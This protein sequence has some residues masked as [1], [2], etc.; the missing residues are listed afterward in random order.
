MADTKVKVP[1]VCGGGCQATVN[2]TLTKRGEPRLPR[3]RNGQW[4]RRED[5]VYCPVC[6]KKLFVL[7]AVTFPVAECLDGEWKDFGAAVRSMCCE[8]ARLANWATAELAKVEPVPTKGKMPDAPPIY[9]YGLLSRFAR[10]GAWAGAMSSAQSILQ[11]TQRK[12]SKRRFET[13]FLMRASLPHTRDTMP[14]PIPEGSTQ[15][16]WQTGEGIQGRQA[17][18]SLPLAGRRWLVRLRGGPE[19]KRQLDAFEKIVSGA[20]EA[21]EV[22]VYF[23]RSEGSHRQQGTS[24]A[25]GGGNRFSVRYFV[26][27]AAW[28]PREERQRRR[29]AGTLMVRTAKNA[30]LVAQPESSCR[31]WLFHAD[32][33][34]RL[35][36]QYAGRLQNLAD[37]TKAEKRRPSRVRR[38][39]NETYDVIR[40]KYHNRMDSEM[41]RIAAALVGYAVRRHVDAIQLDFADNSYCQALA[42]DRLQRYIKERADKDGIAVSSVAT[43]KAT[44]TTDDANGD[45]EVATETATE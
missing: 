45:S 4:K 26:K 42:W 7:R 37:D 25:A 1:I 36:H 30:L 3:G 22:A 17:M 43:S 6:W 2:T 31:P 11:S 16:C 15:L 32:N 24:K 38:R 18:A 14:Y 23:Q 34:R 39:F 9:L 5:V 12:Y 33:L 35:A 13:V 21:G 10:L 27:I 20:A 41:R 28:L 8:S 19:M 29:N 44:T 40:Q